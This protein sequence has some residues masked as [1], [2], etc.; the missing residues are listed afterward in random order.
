MPFFHHNEFG[1]ET[2]DFRNYKQTNKHLRR[3]TAL[4]MHD[5][6]TVYATRINPAQAPM[7]E[8]QRE[9]RR[10]SLSDIYD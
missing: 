4:S 8:V 3:K 6:T 2:N 7:N 9:N 1:L 5:F 10:E